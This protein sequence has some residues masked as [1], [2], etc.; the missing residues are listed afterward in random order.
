MRLMH[1]WGWLVA[2]AVWLA[3]APA[4]SETPPPRAGQDRIDEMFNRYNLH[5]AFHKLGRGLSNALLGW[6]EIPLNAGQRMSSGDTGGSFFT[7]LAYGIAKG[8]VRTAVGVYETVTCFLPYPEDF[9][10]I[11]P[12]L[13]Y[14]KKGERRRPLPLE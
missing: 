6:T 5:P 13:E 8:A 9:A 4:W 10:P 2:I 14:F 3:A 11:L 7:G 1:R 12:T